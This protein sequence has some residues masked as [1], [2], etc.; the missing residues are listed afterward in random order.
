MAST[1]SRPAPYP[2]DTR[3]KGWRFELDM[4]RFKESDTW[5]KA[6][7]GAR[8]AMLLLLWAEAWQQK[9]CGTLPNDDEMVATML[10]MEP[11]EFASHRA[12]LMRGW[13]L[14]DDGRFYHDVLVDR[15]LAML[16]KREKDAK[17]IAAKRRSDTDESR[18]DHEATTKRV[19]RESDTKHQ[20]PE[21]TTVPDG[22]VRPRKRS[23][24]AP[25]LSVAD[26]VADGVAEAHA[27][28]W[29]RI[30]QGKRLPLTRTAWADVKEQA[31][32][33]GMTADEAVKKAVVKGWAGFS[34]K[35]I[36]EAKQGAP[37][38]HSKH[39]GFTQKDYRQG[40]EADGSLA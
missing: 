38:Q 25:A 36:D 17:R 39:S 11:E 7:T 34:A 18:G 22:T 6:R 24:A 40:I 13:W 3:A 2:A 30:R 5:L 16:A 12:V 1:D 10:D 29:L 35:W 19:A 28:D 31:A 23:P 27:G 8:R 9:P 14:A 26:L 37:P 4:E 15:V 21:P 20:A 33:A 32:L